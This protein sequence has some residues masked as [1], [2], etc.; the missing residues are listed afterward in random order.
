MLTWP[1]N[2]YFGMMTRRFSEKN[3]D[4]TLDLLNGVL[5]ALGSHGASS[6]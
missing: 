4:P 1:V 6:G 3:D 2:D 5:D